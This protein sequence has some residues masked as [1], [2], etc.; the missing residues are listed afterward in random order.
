MS[1]SPAFWSFDLLDQEEEEQEEDLST[2]AFLSFLMDGRTDKAPSTN[3]NQSIFCWGGKERK[4]ADMNL[5]SSCC[6]WRG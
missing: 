1:F 3:R 2:L 5:F 4:W 6:W